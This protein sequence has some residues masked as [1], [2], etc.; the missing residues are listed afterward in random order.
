MSGTENCPLCHGTGWKQVQLEN[1][2]AVVRCDCYQ[3]SKLDRLIEKANIPPRYESCSFENFSPITEKLA[4]VRA[5]ALRYV[6][7]YPSV[8]CGL[9]ILGPCGVGKTHLA[10]SILRELIQR[11]AVNGLFCDF[12]ELLKKIQNSYN[13]VSQASEM[14]ILE[15]VL[16]SEVLVMDDLG[17]ERPT[18]W[19]R[20]TFAYIINTRYNQKATTLITSNFEDSLKDRIVL[21]DGSHIGSEE[22][23]TDRI[24]LRLRSR[25]YEMC[26]VIRIEGSDF[27]IDVKQAHHQF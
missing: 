1:R 8:E 13:P 26:K 10:V 16:A 14:Q 21:S 11:H 22:T 18:E 20:D 23:L 15:P 24:G 27:R 7:D 4:L 5:V 19:V 2:L 17:A 6:E 25:L 9:L 3:K 12:R